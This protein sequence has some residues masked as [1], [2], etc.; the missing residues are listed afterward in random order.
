MDTDPKPPIMD[1]GE[2]RDRYYKGI[3]VGLSSCFFKLCFWYKYRVYSNIGGPIIWGLISIGVGFTLGFGIF[4]LTD[5]DNL[6]AS[7]K[8]TSRNYCHSP[9]L[10]RSV[11]TGNEIMWKY[12]VLT[13]G[14]RVLRNRHEISSLSLDF[15]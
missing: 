1:I 3:E 5:N 11:I 10:G 12:R 2:T 8:E 9:M 4:L 6:G 13:V 15:L 7:L 14:I